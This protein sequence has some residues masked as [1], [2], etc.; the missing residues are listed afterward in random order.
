MSSWWNL[1]S[2]ALRVLRRLRALNEMTRLKSV[3]GRCERLAMLFRLKVSFVILLQ[4]VCVRV[5]VLG[6]MLIVAM[7]VLLW[8][9]SV[10][11]QFLL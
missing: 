6:E 2:T 1:V 11:L 8:V 4:W 5:S 3:L 7:W 9:R 10:V